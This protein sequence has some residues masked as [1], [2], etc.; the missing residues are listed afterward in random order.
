[1]KINNFYLRIILCA[2][3]LLF[4][5]ASAHAQIQEVFDSIYYKSVSDSVERYIRKHPNQFKPDQNKMKITPLTAVNYTAEDGVGFFIGIAGQYRNGF[6]TTTPFSSITAIGYIST[7]GSIKISVGGANYSTRGKSRLEYQGSAFYDDRYFWGIGYENNICAT[8]RSFFTESGAGA[9]T[10]YRFFITKN[11]N[12]A[13]LIGFDYYKAS[14]FTYEHLVDGYPLSY[15]GF[16]VGADIV[17]DTRNNQISPSKGVH[18][19]LKQK[20]HPRLFFHTTP[21]YQTSITADFFFKGWKGAVFA[22]DLFSES[23]YGDSPW[24]MWTP[25]GGDTRM[26]GYYYGRYRDRNTLI[27]QIELRQKIYKY[28]GAVLWAGGGNIF[29]TYKELDLKQTLPNYG[30]GYRFEIG[31]LLLKVDVGFGRKSEW[32]LTAGFNHAF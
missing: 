14:S 17:F 31:T 24:F 18:I 30:I 26:R 28:H 22:V 1:M 16:H 2:T 15:T 19:K 21:F 5:T 6:D 25:I 23:N 29:P 20:I 8:N 4:S 27:G 13:P 7:K 10:A 12:A 3:I 9:S 11:I 32:S